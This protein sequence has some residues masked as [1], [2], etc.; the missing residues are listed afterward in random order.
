M[1]AP[2]TLVRKDEDEQPQD[3][4]QAGSPRR[5][6]FPEEHVDQ[7][8]EPTAR[9]YRLAD[10][11]NLSTLLHAISVSKANPLVAYVQ[12]NADLF[13]GTTRHFDEKL[14]IIQ[15]KLHSGEP[16]LVSKAVRELRTF[17]ARCTNNSKAD[18]VELKTSMLGQ[19]TWTT[20]THEQYKL[21]I[22]S[23]Y[24]RLGH[25]EMLSAGSDVGIAAKKIL[26][27]TSMFMSVPWHLSKAGA[28]TVSGVAS[29]LKMNRRQRYMY[30]GGAIAAAALTVS[31][32]VFPGDWFEAPNA[33]IAGTPLASM[34]IRD[35][36]PSELFPQG[37]TNFEFQQGMQ[38][39]ANTPVLQHHYRSAVAGGLVGVHPA[40]LLA[41]SRYETVNNTRAIARNSTAEGSYQMIMETRLHL[42]SAYATKTPTY[43]TLETRVANGTATIDEADLKSGIDALRAAYRADRDGTIAKHANRQ[44]NALELIALN[45]ANRAGFGGELMSLYIQQEAPE[46]SIQALEGKGNAALVDAASYY[47]AVQL[48]GP[49]GSKFFR[50]MAS[51]A[52]ATRVNDI[53]AIKREYMRFNPKASAAQADYY[54]RYYNRVQGGNPDV[55][56]SGANSTFGQ[57]ASTINGIMS[58]N[59]SP[60]LAGMTRGQA[61]AT[62]AVAECETA[63]AEGQG[64][65]NRAQLAHRAKL[66]AEGH[67]YRSL[68]GVFGEKTASIYRTTMPAK[69]QAFITTTVAGATAFFSGVAP[70]KPD[71][72]TVAPVPV[73]ADG[74]RMEI[75]W[76][77]TPAA[78]T[79]PPAMPARRQPTAA[80]PAPTR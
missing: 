69:A 15:G 66:K 26:A 18:P 28:K 5:M 25:S 75:E 36:S 58:S 53:A 64:L 3:M 7:N 77:D 21:N 42:L 29:Y 32:P 30:F 33:A 22:A 6:L 41:V 70:P 67:E 51:A 52:P 72:A 17:A 37:R 62:Q 40:I 49:G 48:M 55:F 1:P 61:I 54:A 50:H 19:F 23:E 74:N 76:V 45:S 43:K 8:P 34:E 14:D 16:K 78:S 39:A 4:A 68:I 73:P 13:L 44:S 20:P 10:R 56:R 24:V 63:R 79:Q 31:V 65:I 11:A 38:T 46:M 9:A 35:C 57:V 60:A 27:G 12:K 2:I 71:P 47:Y 80:G 59:M